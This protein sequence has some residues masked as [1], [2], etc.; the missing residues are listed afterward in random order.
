MDKLSDLTLELE[1]RIK[2]L[3]P[4]WKSEW[5]RMHREGD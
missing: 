3:D 2:D 5:E 1:M 4:S